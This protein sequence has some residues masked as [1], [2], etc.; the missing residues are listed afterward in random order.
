M[1]ALAFN[2]VYICKNARNILEKNQENVHI[3]LDG[4]IASMATLM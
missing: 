2:V 1:L 4:F 3:L